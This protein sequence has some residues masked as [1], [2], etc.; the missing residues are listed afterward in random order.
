VANLTKLPVR[1]TALRVN[2]DSIPE[3]L[4]SRPQWVAWKWETKGDDGKPTKPPYNIKTGKL[5]KSTDSATWAKFSEVV[6]AL[7]HGFDGIGY[8]LTPDDEIV[9]IDIDHAIDSETGKLADEAQ[10]LVDRFDSYTEISVSGGGLH[11]FVRGKINGL[12]RKKG[13]FEIYDSKRFFTVSGAHLQDTPAEIL[14]RQDAIDGFY[15]DKFADADDYGE[16]K[17]K[18]SHPNLLAKTD[19]QSD[20]MS[21]QEVIKKAE[22]AKNGEKFSR[23]FWD[24]DTSDYAS[25]S[26]ADLAL[27]DELYFWC[28]DNPQQ[29]DRIFRRS[30]LYRPK[31][32]EMHGTRT[33]GEMTI[34][35]ACERNL[36][37]LGSQSDNS[38]CDTFFDGSRFVAKR[39]ADDILT[40]HHFLTFTDTEEIYAY[41]SSDGIYRPGGEQIIHDETQRL[42]GERTT[43][44]YVNEVEGYIRRHRYLKRDEL[45]VSPDLI[46]VNNGVLD[47][48]TRKLTPYTPEKPYI[49][50][51]AV[52][53]DPNADCLAFKRYLKETFHEEDI[54]VVEEII[55][56]TLYRS[57][58]HKKGVML[59]GP[60]DNGKSVLLSVE[61]SLLG[62]ENIS[63]R[64]LQDIERDR[65][66]KADLFG[67][68]ANIYA[69]LSSTALVKT[70]TF[71][72]LTGADRVTA[73]RKY[74][75]PFT[76]VNYAKLH[77]SA[78]EL[79]TT[80]DQTPAFFDR[81]ILL[82]PPYR[83]VNH[84]RE[85]CNEKQRDPHLLEKLT[86]EEE[87]SGILNLALDGLDRLLTNGQFTESKASKA[88]KERWI[89]RTDSL[90]AFVKNCVQPKK[91]CFV[92]KDDFFVAYQ[93]YC[94]EHALAAVEKQVVGRRLPTLV[95]TIDYKPQVNGKRVTAWKDIT[96]V[97]VSEMQD[98]QEALKPD[99]QEA[100]TIPDL[101]SFDADVTHVKANSNSSRR[102]DN[103]SDVI[104]TEGE[105]EIT[106]D[107]CDAPSDFVIAQVKERLRLKQAS[108]F[109]VSN[110]DEL[111]VGV[112]N[113]I[114]L[115]YSDLDPANIA[116]KF[117]MVQ[118]SEEGCQLIDGLLQHPDI[119]NSDQ[120]T[121][122]LQNRKL[123]LEANFSST[124]ESENGRGE[125]STKAS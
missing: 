85:H 89:A 11:I 118:Q 82:E 42:L 8:V 58:W 41:D 19:R 46:P 71:K 26:E 23:L 2:E 63:A 99:N 95:Q 66:A 104:V 64:A 55:G 25:Q 18:V 80:K 79:P 67:R 119:S 92:S 116:A 52:N 24:G 125:G 60:G 73:E 22:S 86:S 5:A 20:A 35:K 103:S 124:D 17:W 69:D 13:N 88:V 84:P 53:F 77:F 100:I 4:K 51:I 91:D 59:L 47:R 87:L 74:K 109:R 121:D 112:V 14:P 43:N 15:A 29:I 27:C 10:E 30:I 40:R 98:N 3:V 32:D 37:V 113:D 120:D 83:F 93:D 70:G 81:W 16:A 34:A 102:Y 56:D 65:F 105:C 39:V 97:N 48:R 49:S 12:R 21:D 78:N 31:W 76:F 122:T 38:D 68:F 54:P 90:Q 28:G 1:P 96:V 123:R 45:V 61:G 9:F 101:G 108:G 111:M 110:A 36:N 6:A 33:Y 57:Y 107:I 94:D 44:H 115:D 72:L 50:K 7:K 106:P 75:D 117:R 114:H 62:T